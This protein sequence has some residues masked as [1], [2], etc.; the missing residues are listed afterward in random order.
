MASRPTGREPKRK[1]EQH[2]TAQ[3]ERL[4]HTVERIWFEDGDLALNVRRLVKEARVTTRDLYLSFGGRDQL[5]EYV[6]E[7]LADHVQ[8]WGGISTGT[9]YLEG[10]LQ[11][12]AAWRA[13]V[14]GRGP[15]GRVAGPDRFSPTRAQVSDAVGGD[16]ALAKLDGVVMAVIAGHLDPATASEWAD[17][18]TETTETTET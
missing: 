16:V 5:V 3:A 7:D 6:A 1:A 8:Q 12:P 10:C 17:A 2:S 9:D 18:T 11:R 14:L 13:L 15:A 4:V